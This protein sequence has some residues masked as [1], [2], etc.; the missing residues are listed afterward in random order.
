MK[1]GYAL[2][3]IGL[4]ALNLRPLMTSV[5]P[6]LGTIQRELGLSGA[7]A[8]LLTTLP[9]LCMGLFAPLAARIG[10]RIGMERTI[11]LS[12]LLIAAMTALRAAGSSAAL[13]ILTAI[14]GGIGISLAGPLLSAFVKKTFPT[15]P[16]VVSVYSASMTIGAALASSLSV[17][18]YARSG[19]SLEVALSVWAV[20]GVAAAA[21]WSGFARQS[22]KA[23]AKA[24]S[25]LP[26]RNPQAVKLTLF[27]GLMAGLF[28]S[29]TAWIAPIAIEFGYAPDR[30]AVFL[31]V[32]T[33]IQIPVSLIAPNLSSR[34][35]SPRAVLIACGL[36]ELTGV[37]MLLLGLPM[38]LAVIVIGIGAGGLFPLALMLPIAEAGT[39]EE[40]GGWSAMTQG[41]GYLIGAF[42]PLTIG[43]LRDVTGGFAGPL[44]FV[45]VVIA[46]M[47][48]LQWN[49]TRRVEP[50]A[51]QAA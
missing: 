5:A 42:G 20:L 50:E 30:A 40:A 11:R 1:K 25:V 23:E 29:F 37:A 39:P 4:A 9:V 44:A 49:M 31:T 46:A 51:E 41:G 12:L 2:L 7:A 32:F 17:P 35:G 21:L 22:G 14:V 38:L 6:L 10:D 16:A 45:L 43:A 27:F 24:R 18:V 3:A 47:I 34:L 28:Y 33:V 15:R 13:L 26:L 36:L 8:S 19:G 48:A